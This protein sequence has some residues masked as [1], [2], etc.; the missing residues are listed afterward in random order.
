MTNPQHD[1]QQ[2]PQHDPQ[3]KQEWVEEL[4]VAANDVVAKVKELVQEGN[5]RR[6]IIRKSDGEVLMEVPLTASVVG[7]SA[8]LVFAPTFAAIGA[9][10][11]FV[12]KVRLEVVREGTEEEYED[13]DQ[14]KRKIDID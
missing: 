14:P 13:A 2:D 1:P 4:E 7:G 11:A 10:V 12:T 9:L 5:V 8:L 6:L 3:K